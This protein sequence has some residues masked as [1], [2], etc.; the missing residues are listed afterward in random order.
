MNDPTDYYAVL[1]VSPNSEDIVI[2]AAYRALML[3]YHPDQYTGSKETAES[4]AKEINAAYE[5][6]SDPERRAQYDNSRT[7]NSQ[8]N[9]NI[10]AELLKT[11]QDDPSAGLAWIDRLPIELQLE[12]FVMMAKFIALRTLAFSSFNKAAP[13][14][15]VSQFEI[16]FSE[17][18]RDFA[19]AA[20][21]QVVRIGNNHP[22]YLEQIGEQN[23]R[24]AL[25]AV[26]GVCTA[27]ERLRPGRA[28]EILGWTK[29]KF[30]PNERLKA[31][32]GFGEK[33][34]AELQSRVIDI[35]F[36]PSGK[37]TSALGA[38]TDKRA[39]GIRSVTYF[40]YRLDFRYTPTLGDADQF[41][42]VEL[43]E[44]GTAHFALLNTTAEKSG[45]TNSH[46]ITNTGTSSHAGASSSTTFPASG[47]KVSGAKIAGWII[48]GVIGLWLLAQ[49]G[50]LFN[51][52]STPISFTNV[53]IA[54]SI[55]NNQP[56]GATTLFASAPAMP[57]FYVSY[58]NGRAGDEV[59]I[60]VSSG[61]AQVA[62]CND[63]RLTSPSGYA[64]CWINTTPLNA[65]SY[66]FNLSVNGKIM[67]T[68]PFTIENAAPA[69]PS[70]PPETTPPPSPR[71]DAQSVSIELNPSNTRD[72]WTTSVYSYASGGG[73]PGGGLDND[74]LR[75]GGWGDWYWSLMRF[76]LS[77]NPKQAEHVVLQL[78]NE[79]TSAAATTPFDVY[80][81]DQDWGWNKGDRLWWRNRPTLMHKI[82]S[83]DA[84]SPNSWVNIAITDIYNA[85]QSGQTVNYGIALIPKFNNNN[86]DQF[87]SSKYADKSYRP[88][89]LV[90]ASQ[91][92]SA[93]PTKTV[94]TNMACG[95]ALSSSIYAK[96]QTEQAAEAGSIGC[97]V[98]QEA[99]A[100]PS[101][102]GTQGRLAQFTGGDG[103]Y[104]IM[105]TSGPH[106]GSV[107]HVQG[108]IFMLYRQIGNTQSPLGFPVSDEYDTPGGRQSDFEGGHVHWS[109][110]THQCNVVRP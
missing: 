38:Y 103:N 41:G 104:L 62:H 22:G 14:V 55:Q 51:G 107:Y 76:D 18:E 71:S 36:S 54:Q 10:G 12:D 23:D 70:A 25:Y 63:I 1:G 87:R 109:A 101:P 5:V 2:R 93:V 8:A 110:A 37:V 53:T 30:L 47:P 21:E 85:W 90:T 82:A 52:S 105:H 98:G 9:E 83:V 95:Y 96:W 17:E 34:S 72:V 13:S 39:D 84:P 26:D 50:S 11:C 4:K 99:A 88:K 20:L 64:W 6:L 57:A 7:N 44:D 80:V 33:A 65:G 89:L 24:W 106:A 32:P 19:E 67:G 56:V 77:D 49:I 78:Y 16:L 66:A 75:I 61:G 48:A 42:K 43:F 86:F 3:K 29:L 15:R 102:A 45:N 100:G 79:A 97:P 81:I 46:T 58:T 35:R 69:I 27:L 91:I 59:G 31:L 73:G 108:C 92:A 68:Y 40:L 94:P 28:L 60:S 74:Q